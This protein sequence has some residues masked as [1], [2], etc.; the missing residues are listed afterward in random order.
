MSSYVHFYDSTRFKYPLKDCCDVCEGYSTINS[1]SVKSRTGQLA[2]TLDLK[3]AL[4][5]SL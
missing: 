2:E 1:R 4:K 3:F 5:Q